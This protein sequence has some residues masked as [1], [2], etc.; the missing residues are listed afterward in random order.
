MEDLDFFLEAGGGV[1]SLDLD[2]PLF[3]LSRALKD[4]EYGLEFA[5]VGGIV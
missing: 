4:L 2:A 5:L 1:D 3:F